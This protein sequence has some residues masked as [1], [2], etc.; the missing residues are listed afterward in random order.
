MM[1]TNNDV[2]KEFNKKHKQILNQLKTDEGFD[3]FTSDDIVNQTAKITS[4]LRG[5]YE[6]VFF[7]IDLGGPST[8]INTEEGIIESR[9]GGDVLTT[10]LSF[11]DIERIN[12]YFED[13][14]DYYRRQ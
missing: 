9:F 13:V 2:I 3:E 11:S 7:F 8:F 10:L 14:W 6:S 1:N 4:N 12:S 5:N